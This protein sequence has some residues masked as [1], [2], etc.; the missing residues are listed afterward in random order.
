MEEFLKTLA[1]IVVLLGSL[2]ALG[3]SALD[4]YKEYQGNK[5]T[6][7]ASLTQHRFWIGGGLV[8]FV[9]AVL[10]ATT[11]AGPIGGTSS[12]LIVQV[13]DVA[14]QQFTETG[15]SNFSNESLQQ[16]GAWI[17]AQIASKYDLGAPDL[18]IHVHVPADLSKEHVE[19][20]VNPPGPLQ[21]YF[22]VVANG[23]IKSRNLVAD[24]ALRAVGQDFWLELIRP[25]YEVQPIQVTWKQMLDQDLT[26]HPVPVGVGIEEFGGDKNS[27]ATELANYLV[28][29]PRFSIKDPNAL[30]VLMDEINRAATEQA[31]NPASQVPRRTALGLDLIISGSYQA[32]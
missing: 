15:G 10:I 11:R 14:S 22:W 21:E 19:I 29:N 31:R 8:L 17:T 12:I 6:L 25:G 30:T 2:L 26:L 7:A 32:H 13:W 20:Q 3:K 9:M 28:A 23:G 27:I 18:Q 5:T 4:L 16:V 24:Q 1:S